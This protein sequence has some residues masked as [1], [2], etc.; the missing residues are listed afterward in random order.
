MIEKDPK[1]KKALKNELE[2]I[3]EGTLTKKQQKELQ[4]FK[5]L[6]E[7]K[8]GRKGIRVMIKPGK[9]GEPDIIVGIVRRDR[10]PKFIKSLRAKF[11][12][13]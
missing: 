7:Y 12:T 2:R 4:G 6:K 5:D 10:V 8:F 13:N 11:E 9:K 3:K 1:A